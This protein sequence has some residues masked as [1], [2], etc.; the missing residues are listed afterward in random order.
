MCRSSSENTLIESPPTSL[1][2][3]NRKAK[4]IPRTLGN[5]TG[6]RECCNSA[7]A[8]RSFCIARLAASSRSFAFWRASFACFSSV[9]SDCTPMKC[10]TTPEWSCTGVIER[11][12]QKG[13]TVLLVV[14]K[15]N[16]NR[17][18]FTNRGSQGV[19]SLGIGAAAPKKSAIAPQHIGYGISREPLEASVGVNQRVVGQARVG[20]RNALSA[21]RKRPVFELKLGLDPLAIQ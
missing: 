16:C 12:F 21:R 14:Q 10:V 6:R 5:S 7:A 13:G 3:R 4:F 15:L 9:T 20:Y 18:L 17:P 1:Q 11:R 8:C 19:H 2:G